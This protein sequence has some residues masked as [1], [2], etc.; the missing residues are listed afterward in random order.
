MAFSNLWVLGFF[1]GGWVLDFS[2]PIR[3]SVASLNSFD[4]TLLKCIILIW[5]ILFLD[6]NQTD[7]A[8]PLIHWTAVKPV[9]EPRCPS[10][11]WRWM[12]SASQ[13]RICQELTAAHRLLQFMTLQF[14]VAPFLSWQLVNSAVWAS[15]FWPFLFLSSL[16]S[17][18]P[19][20]G[21][22]RFKR[23]V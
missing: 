15:C 7:I 5:E 22:R 14:V 21:G 4:L 6:E 13:G 10:G 12:T 19:I 11:A 2:F 18:P 23:R 9:V 20:G 17:V 1:L 3:S 8:M 16:L